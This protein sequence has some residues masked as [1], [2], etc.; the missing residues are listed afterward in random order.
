MSVATDAD[1]VD[2]QV[3]AGRCRGPVLVLAPAPAGATCCRASASGVDGTLQPSLDAGSTRCHPVRRAAADPARPAAVVAAGCGAVSGIGLRACVR[4]AA[5]RGTR[6]AARPDRRRH[7]GARP[8]ARRAI[9]HRRAHPP[10]RGERHELLDRASAPCCSCCVG[11]G[12]GRGCAAAV[13]CCRAGRVRRGRPAV[14]ERAACCA[15]GRDR[16]GLARRPGVRGRRCRRWRRRCWRCWSGTRCSAADAGFA[17][18]VLA[19]AA[20]L[21]IAPGWAARLRRWH[22]PIG[23]AEA[24]AVAAAA[25]VVTA[26]VIAAISGSGQP[27][28]DP[29]ERAGRAGR[30][31]GDGARLR[32]GGRR[33]RCGSAGAQALALAGRAGRAAG[34]SGSP[35]GWAGCRAPAC[36]GP[37]ARSAASPCSRSLAVLVALARRVRRWPA[38]RGRCRAGGA[39]ADPGA[40]ARRR[41]GR[42]RAG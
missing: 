36:R 25:H 11:R 38:D 6:A 4:G 9:P 40:F 10:R 15:D 14:A 22:V 26:P 27:G 29:G 17:M 21:L 2:A 41:A 13:G 39:R 5:G 1:V 18:S 12:F 32:R 37:V 31:P 7:G 19:T 8:G 3:A 28:G 30:R 42:R 20:L 35:T 34:W 24:V 23:L 16:A 33:A